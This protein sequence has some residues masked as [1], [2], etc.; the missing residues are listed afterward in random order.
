M[1]D[2]DSMYMGM[3]FL[4]LADYYGREGIEA[5]ETLKLLYMSMKALSKNMLKKELIRCIFELRILVINGEYPN[6]F[7]CGNCGEKENLDY[8][9]EKNSIMICSNCHGKVPEK[10]I[11]DNSTIYALQYIVTSPITRLFSFDVTDKVLEQ[12]K[13]II[14]KY[15][16]KHI[17][18]KFNSLEFLEI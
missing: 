1:K 11:I 16:K 9:D 18:R 8:F 12:M 5:G 17:D 3:Y 6:V 15:I 2:I 13:G 10:N 4:E 7:T 14:N